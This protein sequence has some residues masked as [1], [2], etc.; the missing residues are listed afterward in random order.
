MTRQEYFERLRDLSA[1]GKFPCANASNTVCRYRS[2]DGRGC[3][4]GIALPDDVARALDERVLSGVSNP[5]VWK[6]VRPFL[7]PDMTHDAAVLLQNAHD[8]QRHYDKW[9]HD[10]FV[11]EAAKIL[12]VAA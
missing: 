8:K 3:A 10:R 5:Y 4:L 7:P 9:D 12:N 6:Q 2:E 1:A 11:E